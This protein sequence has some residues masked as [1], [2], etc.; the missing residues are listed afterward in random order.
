MVIS[1]QQLRRAVS[2]FLRFLWDALVTFAICGIIFFLGIKL[3]DCVDDKE[4]PGQQVCDV[5]HHKEIRAWF[6]L[7][8]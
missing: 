6:G 3:L 7:K 1:T 2:Q 4:H 5:K 8:D